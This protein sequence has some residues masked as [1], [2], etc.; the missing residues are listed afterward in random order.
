MGDPKLTRTGLDRAHARRDIA[1]SGENII[2]VRMPWPVSRCCNSKPSNSGI[3]TQPRSN[4]VDLL[5]KV[6]FVRLGNGVH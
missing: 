5:D 1:V 3:A 6:D 2:G 4:T